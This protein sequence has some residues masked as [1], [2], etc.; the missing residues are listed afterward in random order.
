MLLRTRMAVA[1]A[2]LAM[3]AGAH[4]VVIRD[5]VPDGSYRVAPSEF[6]ALVDLPGEGHGVLI[7]PRWVLT[8]AHAVRFG[9]VKEVTILGIPRAVKAKVVHDGFA[10]P[11]AELLKGDSAPLV[12]FLSKNDDVALLELE[13][14]VEDVAPVPLYDGRDE[15][16]KIATLYGKGA[17]GNGLTGQVKDSPHRGEL[18]RANNVIDT[19]DTKWIG[20]TFDRGRDALPLE[21]QLGD[22][23]SGGPVLIDDGGRPTLAGLADWKMP[24]GSVESFRPGIYG[25]RTFQ[26]RVSVYK[27][28]IEK[29]MAF[30]RQ[31]DAAE[32][33]KVTI[34]FGWATLGAAAG[35]TYVLTKDATDYLITGDVNTS[36][37]MYDEMVHGLASDRASIT[38]HRSLGQVKALR[39]LWRAPPVLRDS[40][41]SRLVDEDWAKSNEAS[42]FASLYLN[43]CS[44]SEDAFSKRFMDARRRVAAAAS[45]FEGGWTDDYPRYRVSVVLSGGKVLSMQSHMQARPTIQWF[46]DDVETWNPDIPNRIAALV[47][48]WSIMG[49]RITSRLEG[50]RIAD[51]FG[52][53][54]A[55][56]Q[57]SARCLL[58]H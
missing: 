52:R 9:P 27:P 20:Y 44:A 57:A 50:A 4:A 15:K 23:D 40:A 38:G 1:A 17:T 5:D 32:V 41:L 46:L 6:P 11:G 30:A 21:G 42:V 8:V 26:V 34:E 53:D 35:E 16:G 13:A 10:M 28:W 48:T 14:P 12:A 43:R 58:K 51:E 31:M 24:T 18:R 37:S 7:D 45:Y 49:R 56:Q 39:E 29:V 33:E 19:V 25:Q 3:A 55:I 36:E 2:V 22:G 47:P 54:D